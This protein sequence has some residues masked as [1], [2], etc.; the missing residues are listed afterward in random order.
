MLKRTLL[1]CLALT[2]II[3]AK[4]PHDPSHYTN[5]SPNGKYWNTLDASQKSWYVRAIMD[6]QKNGYNN[7]ST[8]IMDTTNYDRV[9]LCYE[10]ME[11]YLNTYEEKYFPSGLDPNEMAGKLD[12]VYAKKD[13]QQLPIF[14]TYISVW[15]SVYKTGDSWE[16]F[17][18]D[19]PG[20]LV[21]YLL[22]SG[23]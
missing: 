2:F 6:G 15:I 9:D 13:Y 11:E 14:Y 10:N 19:L 16:K 12:L 18:K 7:I 1:F 4:P 3:S 21:N 23:D 20:Y 5:G 17:E 8:T 22:N